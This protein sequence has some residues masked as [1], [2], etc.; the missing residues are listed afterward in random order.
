MATSS[1]VMPTPGPRSS[2]P[3]LEGVALA[4][5]SGSMRSELGPFERAWAAGL[6]L[7]GL[8]SALN[9]KRTLP[10]ED[11]HVVGGNRAA[12]AKTL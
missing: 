3:T 6:A 5:G 12:K 8:G 10:E 4:E 11:K 9:A 7:L 1:R 2:S